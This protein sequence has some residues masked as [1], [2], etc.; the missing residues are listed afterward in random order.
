MISIASTMI[1]VSSKGQVAIPKEFR[2][3]A[4]LETG[5]RL[6][7]EYCSDGTI[8]LHPV[9]HSIKEIFGVAAH[10]ST[11]KHTSQTEDD[12]IASIIAAE[13]EKTKSR[14]AK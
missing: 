3:A 12:A 11:K 1:T 5:T 14:K 4:G 10:G 7:A 6:L 2:V 9:S 13:D 8:S